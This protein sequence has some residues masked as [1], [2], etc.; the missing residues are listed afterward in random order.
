MT[1]DQTIRQLEQNGEADG[2]PRYDILK[3]MQKDGVADIPF[4]AVAMTRGEAGEFFDEKEE[5]FH[6]QQSMSINSA[7]FERFRT[8]KQIFHQSFPA[9]LTRD[10]WCKQ[11]S[12]DSIREKWI[13]LS[14]DISITELVEQAVIDFYQK[15]K[16]PEGGHYT[17]GK[18]PRFFWPDFRETA[19]E[20]FD[21]D[22]EKRL[23]AWGKLHRHY[24][25]VLVIDSI[26]LFHPFIR[27]VLKASPLAWRNSHMGVLILL[28]SENNS[29][30]AL[31]QHINWE[32]Q[33]E[34]GVAFTCL[35]DYYDPLYQF[36]ID[37]LYD[38]N[39]W[40][41][42][43][44]GMDNLINSQQSSPDPDSVQGARAASDVKSAAIVTGGVS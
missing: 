27:N 38:L 26:S 42:T 30:Y 17:F 22:V 5:V 18:H 1:L 4:V 40:L 9:D 15:A 24:N 37:K 43:S 12:E 35:K 3:T 25:S 39:H 14:G 8:L 36:D 2:N 44:N 29:L 33:A 23:K 16:P 7:Q 31:K 41:H 28:P 6:Y 32:I 20:L 10:D 19:G 13:P 11:Y 21:R 34:M